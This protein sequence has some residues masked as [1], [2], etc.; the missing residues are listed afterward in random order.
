LI[1]VGVSVGSTMG[2]LK[3][4]DSTSA[5][6]LTS[7][8]TGSL[9]SAPSFITDQIERVALSISSAATVLITGAFQHRA[10]GLL[11]TWDTFDSEGYGTTFTERYILTMFYYAMNGEQWLDEDNWLSPTL[12]VCH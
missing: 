3:K 1:L 2:A 7:I 9:T 12:H 10:L 4:S 5:F 11:S 6:S 8:L